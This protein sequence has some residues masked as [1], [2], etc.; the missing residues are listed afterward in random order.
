[1]KYS[2]NGENA[3]EKNAS[4]L[5]TE[6]SG[7]LTVVETLRITEVPYDPADF[8]VP[9]GYK[10]S[11]SLSTS[12][13]RLTDERKQTILSKSW[14]WERNSARTNLSN[15]NSFLLPAGAQYFCLFI[16]CFG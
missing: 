13:L 3:Q 4:F 5:S 11:P 8:V 16:V 7:R 14:D 2:T 12:R 15:Q 10:K 9:K 1:M 6:Y